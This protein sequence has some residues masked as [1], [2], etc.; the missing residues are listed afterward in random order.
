MDYNDHGCKKKSGSLLPL[1][2]PDFQ[3]QGNNTYDITSIHSVSELQC[4][5]YETIICGPLHYDPCPPG[6]NRLHPAFRS[7][8]YKHKSECNCGTISRYL[9]RL[10]T[11]PHN[12]PG[13]DSFLSS[14]YSPIYP[15]QTCQG[16][17][18]RNSQTIAYTFIEQI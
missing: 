1:H 10:S 11:P 3:Q 13:T 7:T 17:S 5:L 6:N 2:V 15:E 16:A 9:T 8:G 14:G 18:R 4:V 12:G